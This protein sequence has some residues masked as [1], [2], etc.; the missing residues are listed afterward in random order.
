MYAFNLFD[1]FGG[2]ILSCVTAI[3]DM[4]A[5][6]AAHLQ[7]TVDEHLPDQDG[8]PHSPSLHRWYAVPAEHTGYRL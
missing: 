2:N 7:V 1:L 3:P 4:A 6:L 5:M 8:R